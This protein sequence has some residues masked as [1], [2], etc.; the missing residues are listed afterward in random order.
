MSIDLSQVLILST[1]VALAL[2]VFSARTM[3]TDRVVYLVLL[4][5]G[6]VLAL[7]PTV[8]TRVANLV[9]IGRGAD[10]LLYIFLLFS[11]FHYAMQASRMKTID[12]RITTLVR[13]NAMD[14]PVMG[15]RPANAPIDTQSTT[16][17]DE[18]LDSR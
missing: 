1:I 16:T 15:A 13:E 8:S 2:Y 6:V 14:H 12:Q 3:L 17:L 7:N 11:L 4:S 9:G 5:V 18:E 10:L